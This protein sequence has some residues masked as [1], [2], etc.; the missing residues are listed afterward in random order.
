MTTQKA[1]AQQK[2]KEDPD[3]FKR[4]GK[5]GGAKTSGYAFAHGRLDPKTTGKK[6]G[7]PRKKRNETQ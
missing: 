1:W 4:I 5:K 2:L 6:G 3:Y 7:R